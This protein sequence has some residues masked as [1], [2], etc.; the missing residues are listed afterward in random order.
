MIW[1]S[2]RCTGSRCLFLSYP[3]TSS[4]TARELTALVSMQHQV[5]SPL[6]TSYHF[7]LRSAPMPYVVG[8]HKSLMP[9][10]AQRAMEGAAGSLH[11]CI[12]VRARWLTTYTHACMYVCPWAHVLRHCSEHVWVD[13]D[14]DTVTS[15]FNDADI[16]PP[17][18]MVGLKDAAKRVRSLGKH[19]AG[20]G[21]WGR[22]V[23]DK[24][25]A[26][27]A[28]YVMACHTLALLVTAYHGIS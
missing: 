13:L 2:F 5:L 11:A 8:V 20:R 10:V 22:L 1:R 27:L 6:A 14:T 12:G 21:D 19:A 16:V 23:V 24:G 28:C 17:E 7:L 26:Y 18:L 15:P 4:T 3:T 25:L 9:S